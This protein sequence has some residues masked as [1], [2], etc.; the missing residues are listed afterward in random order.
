[1]VA[2]SFCHDRKSALN[3]RVT[4]CHASKHVGRDVTLEGAKCNTGVIFNVII[5]QLKWLEFGEKHFTLF[6]L[7]L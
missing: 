2:S 3:E 6:I 5:I 4:T 1:M 7:Y